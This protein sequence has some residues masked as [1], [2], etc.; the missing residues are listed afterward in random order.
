VIIKGNRFL[1]LFT[2][3]NATVTKSNWTQT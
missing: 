3:E 2:N 1:E